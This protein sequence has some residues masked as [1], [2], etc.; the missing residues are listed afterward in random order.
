M[1][2]II[3]VLSIFCF[4]SGNIAFS[5]SENS[6]KSFSEQNFTEN[7]SIVIH[8][9]SGNIVKEN[10]SDSMEELYRQ[11]LKEAIKTGHKILANG[12]NALE[13]V[14]R[15]INIL[16]DSPLFNAGKGAVLTHDKAIELDASIMD[17]KT[18]NAGAVAGVTTIKNPINLAHE[19]MIASEHVLLAGKGAERFGK[20]QGIK[21]VNP[22]YFYTQNQSKDLQNKKNEIFGT[23]GCV[24][25]DKDGNL[26][27]GTSTGE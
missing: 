6:L 1:K 26:A 23:V 14:Q 15:S 21:T 13:A 9:G 7:F 19:V 3:L 22:G 8:G 17:G 24:A 25:L 5:Q 2:K 4:I 16:E 20:E 10:I 11:K 18:L 12:G 27:A